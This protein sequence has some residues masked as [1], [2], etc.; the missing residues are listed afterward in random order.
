MWVLEAE[1]PALVLGSTSDP[2]AVDA[3]RAAERGFEIVRRRSGGGAV[4]LVPGEHLWVD[5]WVPRGHV[6]ASDDVA[7]GAFWAGEAFAG[8]AET[9]LGRPATVRRQGL[10]NGDHGAAVCFAGAG[11]GEVFAGDRKLVGISQRRTRDWTRIQ[12]L[13]HQRWQ[14]ELLVDLLAV[15]GPAAEALKADLAD[16]VATAPREPLLAALGETLAAQAIS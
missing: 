9:V 7:R 11:P 16:T 2:S 15:E 14:P 12:T 1:L 13:V 3:Q 10:D 6:L 4:L 5:F 8:A